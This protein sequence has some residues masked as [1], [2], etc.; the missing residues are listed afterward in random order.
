MDLARTCLEVEEDM[1]EVVVVD[2]AVMVEMVAVPL[3]TEGR[4]RNNSDGGKLSTHSALD[5]ETV[6]LNLILLMQAK[7]KAVRVFCCSFKSR[8]HNYYYTIVKYRVHT[9]LMF[10]V[11]N[12]LQKLQYSFLNRT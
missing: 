10:C 5:H 3:E 12:F 1:E 6:Q 7:N 8:T 4:G 2:M 11:H 9:T